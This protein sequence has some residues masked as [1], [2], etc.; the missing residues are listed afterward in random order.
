PVRRVA[1]KLLRAFSGDAR[2]AQPGTA[3]AGAHEQV[4]PGERNADR[5]EPRAQVRRRAG[6][7]DGEG[8]HR[9]ASSTASG[10]IASGSGFARAIAAC[11]SFRP[12]PVS[13]ATSDW[14][15]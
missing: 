6:H 4:R 15:A 10:A 14:P 12:W 8:A 3:G 11:G 13:T 9:K 1:R 7:G 5:V 2:D